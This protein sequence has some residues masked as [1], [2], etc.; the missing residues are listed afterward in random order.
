M[1]AYE[2][3]KQLRGI[4]NAILGGAKLEEIRG[5]GLATS[6][7]EYVSKENRPGTVRP[8]TSIVDRSS[9]TGKSP[10]SLTQKSKKVIKEALEGQL[11]LDLPTVEAS[12]LTGSQAKDITKTRATITS[13]KNLPDISKFDNFEDF[14]KQV[15]KVYPDL[16][17]TGVDESGRRVNL[18]EEFKRKKFLEKNAGE[19]LETYKEGQPKLILDP[20]I[21]K[22]KQPNLTAALEEK[23]NYITKGGTINEALDDLVDEYKAKYPKTDLKTLKNRIHMSVAGIADKIQKEVVYDTRI[24]FPNQFSETK[25]ALDWAKNEFNKKFKKALGFGAKTGASLLALIKSGKAASLLGSAAGKSLPAL[26]LALSPELTAPELSGIDMD[27]EVQLREQ[28]LR[29]QEGVGS[30]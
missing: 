30:L 12:D 24:K 29:N 28:M 22:G 2:K 18:L 14:Y 23:K 3:I 7:L 16:E 11:G 26:D 15:K 20:N 13:L 9:G 19:V 21:N 4:K 6:D 5:E 1:S 27:L 25:E 8:K 17:M 10:V